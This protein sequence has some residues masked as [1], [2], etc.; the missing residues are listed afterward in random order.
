MSEPT[1]NIFDPVTLEILKEFE[2]ERWYSY[3]ISSV[4]DTSLGGIQDLLATAR[5]EFGDEMEEWGDIAF[6]LYGAEGYSRYSI[7][8]GGDLRLDKGSVRVERQEQAEEMGI[9]VY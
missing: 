9:P 1:W 7:T 5:E 6:V 3:S 4:S 2:G 8:Y